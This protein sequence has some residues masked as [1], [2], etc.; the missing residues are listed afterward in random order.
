MTRSRDHEP[1]YLHGA[2]ASEQAR[3]EAMVTI[4]GGAEFLP[5][6]RRGMRILEVGCGTGTIAREVA[7]RIAPGQIIGVDQQE[8]QLQ[9][10]GRI[11]AQ[12]GIGNVS[13][14]RSDAAGLEF[15]DAEFDGAYCRFLLEH[16]ADPTGVVREM[17]RVVRPGGWVCAFEWENGC[18]VVYP[19][20]PA[21]AKVWQALYDLQVAMG[22]DAVIAR[23]LY[24]ILT[25]V[26]LGQVKA[27]GRAWSITADDKEKL[28]V[29]VDGAR[30]IIRQ[31]RDRLLSE[32]RVTEE[33]LKQADDEYQ[34]LLDSPVTFVMEGYGCATGIRVV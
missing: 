7:E 17:A 11:A 21:V 5:P 9:T 18:S 13:F 12:R 14:R 3:L 19:D 32:R 2:D 22:G 28:R 23:K 16:V 26:G 25:H 31:G 29:Y 27:E 4:L 20:S 34:R 6:L 24:G 30:E 33:L 8:A 15:P 1:E 10:A